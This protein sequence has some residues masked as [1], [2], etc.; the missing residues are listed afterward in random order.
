[1]LILGIDTCSMSSSVALLD[2]EKM[3]AQFS[4]NHKKTHSERIMSQIESMLLAADIDIENIDAFAVSVGPGSFTG[5]RIGVATA[6]GFAQ[7]LNKPCIKVS[8][9]RAL[10]ENVSFFSG[11][12][13]P[14]LDARRNQVYNAV[15]ESEN[16][17][18]KRLCEDR[19]IPLDDLICELKT[20]CKNIMFVGDGVPVFKEKL[21]SELSG[22]ALFAPLPLMFNQAA[23]VAAVGMDEYKNG[24][25][26]DYSELVPE[27][28]RLSQAEQEKLRKENNDV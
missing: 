17:E 19:A 11:L 27:Y 22:K 23:S 12:I 24:N 14:I 2:E 28:V 21:L 9:L 8:A 5:V 26:T 25:I 4:I 18:I 1:M 10:C 15:F 13:C 20:S 7:A 3:L 16:G 6:K